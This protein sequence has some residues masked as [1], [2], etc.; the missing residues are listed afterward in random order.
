V[1]AAEL[2]RLNAWKIAPTRT[3]VVRALWA[4]V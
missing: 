3:L 2:L 1:N 4:L